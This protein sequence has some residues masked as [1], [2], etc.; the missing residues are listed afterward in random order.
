MAHKDG[1]ET[2]NDEGRNQMTLQET[3]SIEDVR[4]LRQQM[5]EMYKAWTSGQALSFSIVTI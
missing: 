5:A 2:D 1:N 3:V 4:A